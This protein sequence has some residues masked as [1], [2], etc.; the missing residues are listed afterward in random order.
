MVVA[1]DAAAAKLA[2]TVAG[3]PPKGTDSQEFLKKQERELIEVVRER[4]A[5][6]EENEAKRKKEHPRKPF[7]LQARQTANRLELC[8]DGT[9]VIAMVN[10][11]GNGSKP[12]NVESF[13]NESAYTEI[14]PGRTDVGDAQ[15]RQRVAI[16][17]VV[18]GEAKWVDPAVE[19]SRSAASGSA[20]E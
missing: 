18:T 3:A 2:P 20:M 12:D 6:R 17:D 9:C 10:E 1:E 7:Q 15:G 8:P 11:A 13:V 5:L 19:Q 4:A 14:I 16:L